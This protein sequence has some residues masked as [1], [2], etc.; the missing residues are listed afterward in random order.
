MALATSFQ[1]ALRVRNI[2]EHACTPTTS[3]DPFSHARTTLAGLTE[4][5][6]IAP[7]WVNYHLEHHLFMGIPCWNL[8][9]AH[10]VLLSKGYADRMTVADSYGAV[11][12]EVVRSP[13]AA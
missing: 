7:Y 13:A 3:D 12:H 11:M 4:R 6:L 2:A 8:D 5:A 10:R 1:L 9:R